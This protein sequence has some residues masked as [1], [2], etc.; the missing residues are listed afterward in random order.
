MAIETAQELSTEIEQKVKDSSYS[1]ANVLSVLNK[2]LKYIAGQVLL[3]ALE[4]A[5]NAL[6]TTAATAYVAL[7]TDYHRNL[8]Y[9]YS[10]DRNRIIKVYYSYSDL[11]KRFSQIDLAGPV[12]GVAVK[13]LSLYYQKVPVAAESLMIK[14][15]K[16]PTAL[17][18]VSSSP[19]CLPEHLVRPLLVNY[20]CRDI[21]ADKDNE[22][23]TLYH[24]ALF[25]K[26]IA[27]LRLF[28]NEDTTPTE[29]EGIDFNAFLE[30]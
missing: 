18:L 27:D 30:D 10:N 14:Y 2:A 1:F 24:N 29:L 4:T 15:Y 17:T 21:F 13:T 22:K 7:P 16:M 5:N 8:Y 3:P 12:Y 26:A 9:C 11:I 19:S 28:A 25:D 6:S 23:K 20:V